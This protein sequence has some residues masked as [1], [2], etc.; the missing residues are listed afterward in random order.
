VWLARRYVA[1]VRF[2]AATLE[3][4][5]WSAGRLLA[6]SA[7]AAAVVATVLTLVGGRL[8]LP[9][10]AFPNAP[11]ISVRAASM[12]QDLVI[13]VVPGLLCGVGAALAGT[14]FM[15]T[16][17]R[18]YLWLSLALTTLMFSMLHEAFYPVVLGSVLTSADVLRFATFVLLSVGVWEQLRRRVRDG[19]ATVDG[20][21]QELALQGEVLASMRQFAA[22]EEAFRSVVVHEL[23]TPL[24]TLRAFAHV[25]D[26]ELGRPNTDPVGV[27]LAGIRT[28]T[29]RLQ[30]LVERMD[31]L[32]RLEIADFRCVRR[33]VLLK[34]LAPLLKARCWT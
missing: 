18:I 19:A 9:M 30:D 3:R 27:A 4:P 26:H 29:R 5:A 11:G 7:A 17:A 6:V 14:V 20:Q 33:P 23:A 10:A 2:I 13:A 32:R 8:R 15:R 12:T 21:A 31:E 16:A 22:R 24:A 25:I 1:G 34:P 28:E